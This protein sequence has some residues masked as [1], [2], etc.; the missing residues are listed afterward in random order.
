MDSVAAYCQREQTKSGLYFYQ[1][2]YY[3]PLPDRFAQADTI[4]PGGAQGLDRY[5]YVNTAPTWFTD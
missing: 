3:D 4:I 1:S 2:G 5:A